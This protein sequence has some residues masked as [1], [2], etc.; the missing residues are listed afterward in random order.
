[1]HGPHQVAQ[2]SMSSTRPRNASESTARWSIAVNCR[3]GKGLP[4]HDKYAGSCGAP[5]GEIGPPVV[6]AVGAV[7]LAKKTLR[8]VERPVP[9]PATFDREHAHKHEVDAAAD[10]HGHHDAH[11]HH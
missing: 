6:A 1:M 7:V 2:K 10:D 8:Y 4:S 11:G 3:R 9:P 5:G